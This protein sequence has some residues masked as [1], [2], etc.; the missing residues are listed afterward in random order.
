M[1]VLKKGSKGDAVRELQRLLNIIPQDGVF[2]MKTDTMVKAYQKKNGLYPD[3]IV[4][5]KTWS[6]L[7]SSI[8]KEDGITIKKAFIGTRITKLA[9]R[10]IK[11]LAIHYTAGSTSKAG[12]AL[13][14]RNVFLKRDVSADFVVDDAEIVQVN[15]DPK[16]YFCWAVG[17]KK[18]PYTGGGRLYGTATN[19]N[20]ISIEICSNLRQGTSAQYPNHDGWSFTEKSLN[21]ALKLVRYLMKK[22]NI[23]KDR[24]VRHY[25]ISGKMCPAIVGW[26]DAPTYTTNGTQCAHKS[27]SVEWEKFKARI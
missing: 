13:A 20:T 22:Y 7:L 9:N 25:D 11:F 2:G 10:D 4:G 24:V 3:G 5:E 12:A 27:T 23:P 26:N 8:T 14:T 6:L 18:N 1:E 21:N 16:N 15:P 17:D 19:R